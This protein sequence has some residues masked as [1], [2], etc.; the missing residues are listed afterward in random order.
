M[1][2]RWRWDVMAA[3]LVLLLPACGGVTVIPADLEGRVDQTVT[4]EQLKSSP[5]SFKGR[6]VVLGG[7]VLSARRLKEATRI[8]LLQ[9][10]LDSS[11]EPSGRPIDSRGRFL[12]FQKTF[13]DP[14]AVPP[15]TRVT[16]VGKSPAP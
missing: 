2:R 10:P 14:A 3:W 1:G 6:L 8:E 5:D 13:L 9:L 15:G 7:N 4:F 12:A 16:V 11:L